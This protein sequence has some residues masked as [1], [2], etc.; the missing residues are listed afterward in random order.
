MPTS[1]SE[2]SSPTLPKT[3][4]LQE[5]CSLRIP[6]YSSSMATS[7]PANL[8]CSAHSS[9][10]SGSPVSAASWIAFR[11]SHAS[12]AKLA[13]KASSLI[14]EAA[15]RPLF[16]NSTAAS[17]RSKTLRVLMAAASVVS[18]SMRATSGRISH[19]TLSSLAEAAETAASQCLWTVSVV[20]S[21]PPADRHE[22]LCASG[23]P[24][25]SSVLFDVV[26]VGALAAGLSS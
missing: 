4:P 18:N 10:S 19:Q 23:P 2:E 17:I 5:A 14:L 13:S 11:V 15:A 21:R 3:L 8:A 16:S 9:I 24:A 1:S 20:C 22:G 7:S 6:A 12:S 25:V 26:V